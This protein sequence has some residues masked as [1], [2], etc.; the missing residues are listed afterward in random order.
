MIKLGSSLS[1]TVI[2]NQLFYSTSSN[3]N[4][5]NNYDKD[6]LKPK[7]NTIY[8]DLETILSKLNHDQQQNHE[9]HLKFNDHNNE[10]GHF[11]R[12]TKNSN[13]DDNNNNNGIFEENSIEFENQYSLGQPIV[14]SSDYVYS[15]KKSN[16][17]NSNSKNKLK[18][19][20]NN[21]NNNNNRVKKAQKNKVPLLGEVSNLNGLSDEELD[22]LME[23]LSEIQLDVDYNFNDMEI[24]QFKN[25]E[26]ELNS[27]KVDSENVD[28]EIFN[29]NSKN[30]LYDLDWNREVKT[31]CNIIKSTKLGKEEMRQRLMEFVNRM[32]SI[33]SLGSRIE[34]TIVYRLIFCLVKVG[35]AERAAQILESLP[36]RLV[37][38]QVPSFNCIVQALP[39]E[40][41]TEF[42]WENIRLYPSFVVKVGY[43]SQFLDH[44]Y[45]GGRETDPTMPVFSKIV[46]YLKLM[47]LWTPGSIV[48][49]LRFYRQHFRTIK[50]VP[51]LLILLARNAIK[52]GNLYE[53]TD[54]V[55]LMSV[56]EIVPPLKLFNDLLLMALKKEGPHGFSVKEVVDSLKKSPVFLG[57]LI[58][59]HSETDT[60]HSNETLYKLLVDGIEQNTAV[61]V[62]E[63]LILDCLHIKRYE[64]ALYWYSRLVSVYNQ[65]PSL[66]SI[67]YFY[68]HDKQERSS[69]RCT[70]YWYIRIKEL[71]IFKTQ[72]LFHEIKAIHESFN[73]SNVF[74][75]FLDK[76]T[77]I[78]SILK[79]PTQE[80]DFQLEKMIQ[81]E[82]VSTWNKYLID[83]YFSKSIL[84]RG[85]LVINIISSLKRHSEWG[86]YRY[87]AHT[88]P[89]YLRPLSFNPM[90]YIQLFHTLDQNYVIKTLS[91]EPTVLFIN[92]PLI[93]YLILKTLVAAGDSQSSLRGALFH[94]I[95]SRSVPV[96]RENLTEL[97]LKDVFPLN[98]NTD[99]ILNHIN[100]SLLKNPFKVKPNLNN[101]EEYGYNDPNLGTISMRV[102][103]KSSSPNLTGVGGEDATFLDNSSPMGHSGNNQFLSSDYKNDGGGGGVGSIITNSDGPS[104]NSISSSSSTLEDSLL[105]QFSLRAA[106]AGV[107]VGGLMCF[108]NMYFGLQ[109]G[110][111]TMG[112]LQSTLLGFIFFK[113]IEKHLQ[114]RFNHFENVVLQTIAVATATMPLAGGFVGII[115][116]LKMYHEEEK[117]NEPLPEYLSWWS[118]TLWTLG[119]AFFGVFFA[120]PLRKQT[121]LV[122]K[123]KFPSGTAT[124]QMIKVLHNLKDHQVHS[125]M[126][127]ENNIVYKELE[128]STEIIPPPTGAD[129]LLNI[130]NWTYFFPIVGNLPIFGTYLANSWLWSLTPS[131]SYVGQ[132]MIMGS[133]TGISMLIG[134]VIGWGVL[135]PIAKNAGWAPGPVENWKT[136]SKGWIL[137][138]SLFIMLAESIV[139][140]LVILI[141]ALLSRY[142]KGKNRYD[143]NSTADPAPINQRVP[144]TWWIGGLVISSIACIAIISP[145]F[146]VKVY[147]TG[148]AIIL[149]LLTSVLAV[150]ALGETD[151]NPVSGIGKISQI[152]FAVVA[153]KNVLSNLVA[154]AI[155]EAGAQ[156]AGDMMQDLKTGHLLKASPRVQFYGQLIGSFFSIIFA[157]V[158]Y[159]LYSAAY[160]IGA[161]TKDGGLPAPT[162]KVWLDM[163]NLVNHGQLAENVLGFC[164]VA[165]FLVALIP[166][167]EAIK[168]EYERYLPSGI[169]LAI[170]M[171]ITPNWILPRCIGSLVQYVWKRKYPESFKDYMIIVA[172]GFVLGEGITSI[173]TA[174]FKIA[175]VPQ[176]G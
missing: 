96:I 160:V 164:I 154:G 51:S 112:S 98:T 151:L 102:T 101:E 47:K 30:D 172:S 88:A 31:H 68:F 167:I 156:Q 128:E 32:P 84:P 49:S 45:A 104:N 53:C 48:E 5:N 38:S 147:E 12:N 138:V 129:D 65:R 61:K 8:S 21:N 97:T 18:E 120:V 14:H 2:N 72:E 59:Y 162:A 6:G 121:I 9:L 24:I 113:L 145:L 176:V 13:N 3:S 25:I 43:L 67:L 39:A 87:Y 17:N 11:E 125:E 26:K 126:L 168:P 137:W 163:A 174:I 89:A 118:L 161:P 141:Q 10:C 41:A 123:L 52:E 16:N 149:A 115:P 70:L 135:S 57:H 60:A 28:S 83:N 103:P 134:A 74:R 66:S 1:R 175:G 36:Q 170:G 85:N 108:S 143:E 90:Y 7:S 105:R 42:F 130:K 166:I 140:L 142:G 55:R 35:E 159:Q 19:N 37:G 173:I 144:R 99:F 54:L 158:S 33:K 63:T 78:H 64:K 136:G 82:N 58:F 117:P 119:L 155:A 77:K 92:S 110:W 69:E 34:P 71:N 107:L 80:Y 146:D 100:L 122:E 165:A 75:H 111:V 27:E 20:N 106:I 93:N 152:V 86:V 157:V 40:R 62:T 73:L 22:S 127:D 114:V 44:L 132:G 94:S 139:S 23:M 29:V 76:S 79:K 91:Q 153:P 95:K 81:E 169:A 133:K 131:L 124:A 15:N 50:P 46:K 171:Y 109:A 148:I 56:N 150:R 116:A 4:I